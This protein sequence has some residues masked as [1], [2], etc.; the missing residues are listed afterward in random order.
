[1]ALI[2]TTILSR[3]KVLDS[4]LANYGT[5]ASVRKALADGSAPLL[6]SLKMAPLSHTFEEF[7]EL[8]RLR[9]ALSDFQPVFPT[10]VPK[11]TRVQYKLNRDYVPYFSHLA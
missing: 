6:D 1:M 5:T 2:L 10:P 3:I 7:C 4:K 9:A 11:L 8:R